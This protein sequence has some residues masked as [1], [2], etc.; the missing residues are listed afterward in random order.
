MTPLPTKEEIQQAVAKL[1]K[2]GLVQVRPPLN[3]TPDHYKQYQREIAQRIS[4]SSSGPSPTV[5]AQ[6]THPPQGREQFKR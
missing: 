3:V 1:T 6:N 5:E 2:Q 4:A